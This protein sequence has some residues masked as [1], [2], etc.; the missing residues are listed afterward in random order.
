MR[1]VDRATALRSKAVLV[2]WCRIK[3]E[4]NWR[5]VSIEV[6]TRTDDWETESKP[7]ATVERMTEKGMR[8]RIESIGQRYSIDAYSIEEVSSLAA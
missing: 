4:P 8:E 2:K 6:Q 7:E 1:K 5:L 3:D